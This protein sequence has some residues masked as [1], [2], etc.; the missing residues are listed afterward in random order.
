MQCH[1]FCISLQNVCVTCQVLHQ[2]KVDPKIACTSAKRLA[3]PSQG[4]IHTL[5]ILLSAQNFFFQLLSRRQVQQLT[6]TGLFFC[7]DQLAIIGSCEIYSSFH[8]SWGCNFPFYKA[9]QIDFFFPVR[10]RQEWSRSVT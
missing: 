7:I 8:I 3:K 1:Y 4:G 5:G 2:Q 6:L 10:Q 9:D